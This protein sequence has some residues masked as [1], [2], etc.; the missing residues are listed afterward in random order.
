VVIQKIIIALKSPRKA[1][2][3]K[4]KIL[5][6]TFLN[7]FNNFIASC[8]EISWFNV[9]LSVAER[10]IMSYKTS[11]LSSLQWDDIYNLSPNIHFKTYHLK[12]QA[13]DVNWVLL[14]T[15]IYC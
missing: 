10:V 15:V 4:N 9:V 12:L 5:E 1:N 8:T 14:V 7:S 13:C 6:D 3:E 11:H 2:L